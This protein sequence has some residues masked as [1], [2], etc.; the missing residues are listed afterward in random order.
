MREQ[1]NATWK[2]FQKNIW[3][4]YRCSF[5]DKTQTRYA[6]FL[7]S[8]S[9]E[10]VPFFLFFGTFK[11]LQEV[12]WPWGPLKITTNSCVNTPSARWSN[13]QLCWKQPG[14]CFGFALLRSVIGP[15]NSRHLIKQSVQ[16][17][18]TPSAAFSRALRG[19]LVFTLSCH[20]LF[21]AFSVLLI[22]YFHFF[23]FGST[24]LIEI[25]LCE[26]RG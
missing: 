13:F 25:T 4:Y 18:T 2:S 12:F 26:A 20:W 11:R 5:V 10:T 7:Q 15:E 14:D 8:S 22:S 16:P 23:G 1:P 9:T 21:K 3:S 6:W 24:T 19:L 17:F